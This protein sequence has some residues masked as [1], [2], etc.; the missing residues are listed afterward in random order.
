[1]AGVIIC[2]RWDWLNQKPLRFLMNPANIESP[3]MST[4]CATHT[5]ISAEWIVVHV[6]ACQLKIHPKTNRRLRCCFCGS[7]WRW[8]AN[9]ASQ[10]SL[11]AKLMY[12]LRLQIQNQN[13]S[14]HTQHGILYLPC[15]KFVYWDSLETPVSAD[16][17]DR[18]AYNPGS[19]QSPHSD[20]SRTGS[21]YW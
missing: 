14:C 1:M 10:S 3:V 5:I 4:N 15:A 6:R 2:L 18:T 21:V 13:H 20:W 9:A 19:L 7:R 16:L 11:Y 12:R 8:G 17:C